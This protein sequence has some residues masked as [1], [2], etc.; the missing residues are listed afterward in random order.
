MPGS[1]YNVSHAHVVI[2]ENSPVVAANLK[3][4]LRELGFSDRLVVVVKDYKLLLAEFRK[5]PVDL[6]VCDYQ[7]GK[8]INGGHILEDLR[9]R[10]LLPKACAVMMLTNDIDGDILRVFHDT[11]V[12]DYL[13]K[14]YSLYGMKRKVRRLCYAKLL[15]S[16]LHSIDESLGSEHIS[17]MFAKFH[18]EHPKLRVESDKLEGLVY[19]SMGDEKRAFTHFTNCAKQ[20]KA[21]WA[22]LGVADCLIK[23][24]YFERA[25]QYLQA[26]AEKTDAA[27]TRILDRLAHLHLLRDNYQGAVQDLSHA[28]QLAPGSQRRLFAMSLINEAFEQPERALSDFHQF[29]K[30][31]VRV[32]FDRLNLHIQIMRLK[33]KVLT[34][35]DSDKLASISRNAGLLSRKI[36]QQ[37]Q[38][39]PLALVSAHI[40]LI[41]DDHKTASL[42]LDSLMQNHTQLASHYLYYLLYLLSL[43]NLHEG[44]KQIMAYR[45]ELE[46]SY[47]S[48][49]VEQ[50]ERVRLR[51]LS[52][53]EV[54]KRETLH[55]T[56]AVI[57]KS[58]TD[59][60]DKAHTEAIK[61]VNTRPHCGP[62][63]LALLELFNHQ[64]PEHL[65][66]YEI[67][68]LVIHCE[69]A[70]RFS[71]SL[72]EGDKYSA[73]SYVRGA[74]KHFNSL[75]KTV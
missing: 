5:R 70:V 21:T 2:A 18:E 48:P 30:H 60:M 25:E 14:P 65:S 3:V 4:L 37:S 62:S 28:E 49:I 75:L 19:L 72:D 58:K 1:L 54:D 13:T 11:Q 7:F 33:L 47:V 66:R 8:G 44:F 17:Q 35:T 73:R 43:A 36:S 46:I 63:A 68:R 61:L 42:Y 29:A 41:Q 59:N 26:W 64:L 15:V 74:K 71:I 12:D 53:V 10:K 67:K 50:S 32:R 56:L 57:Q 69:E 23:L 16:Q 27:K 39:L 9:L 40:A 55:K 45:D 6:F 38:R 52:N 22:W 34:R 20:Y 51:F 24:G 31:A